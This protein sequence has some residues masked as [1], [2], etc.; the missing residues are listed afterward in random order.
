MKNNITKTSAIALSL[1][2]CLSACSDRKQNTDPVDKVKNINETAA[3]NR[4]LAVVNGESIHENDI[5]PLLQAGIDRAIALDRYINRIITAQTALKEYENQAKT[6]LKQAERDI[7]SNLYMQQE[8]QRL[9]KLITEDD[10]KRQYEQTVRPEDY[11]LFKAKY[12]LSNDAQDAENVGTLAA[13][14]DTNMRK[15][16]NAIKNKEDN[17][18]R[19]Q[20]FPYGIGQVIKQLKTDEFSKP[21]ATRNG[22]FIVWIE[23]TK[24]NPP[25]TFDRVKGEL[26]NL[27][28][29]QKI[30]SQIDQ[31][32]AKA[33]IELK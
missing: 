6:A 10:L 16:F 25:P 5:R 17:W 33:K 18:L 15:A 8:T 22:F 32:R 19:A 31:K 20:D 12:Y 13:G 4:A 30:S 7:L 1:M 26:K 11:R 3:E 9:E 27:I 28:I 21:I 24:D 2:L 29:A 14:G 23:E